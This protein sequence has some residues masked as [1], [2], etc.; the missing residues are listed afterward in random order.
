MLRKTAISLVVLTCV[1]SAGAQQRVT[2]DQCVS[3]LREIA[4]STYTV[5]SDKALDTLFVDTFCEVVKDK[6]QSTQKT[7]GG[8][9]YDSLNIK[10]TND[11]S[12]L[13][14]YE[15][16]YCRTTVDKLKFKSAYKFYAS[17]VN[18]KAGEDF[19]KCM[20]L[21]A[22][23]E[24]G[25]GF[26]LTATKRNACSTELA[27]SYVRPGEVGP[28]TAKVKNVVEVGA[29][30]DIRSKV[31]TASPQPTMCRRTSWGDASVS[32]GTDQNY[33]STEFEPV[34]PP[35]APVPP[36]IPQ[37]DKMTKAFVIEGRFGDGKNVQA[38]PG[39]DGRVTSGILA[40]GKDAEDI[41]VTY[42]CVSTDNLCGFSFAN[43]VSGA[44]HPVQYGAKWSNLG[45]GNVKWTRLWKGDASTK[46]VETY[47]ATWTVPHVRT[48]EENA[49]QA[50]YEAAVADHAAL[51]A[52]GPCPSPAAAKPTKPK[53][54]SSARAAKT[55][56]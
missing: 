46:I 33:R 47:T 8:L 26:V 24:G 5:D 1:A 51:L 48:A 20:K 44:P 38:Q 9:L 18:P 54:A 49:K 36:N 37:R 2:G 6:R 23:S 29:K 22:E 10:L 17:V 50:A 31:L 35:P 16:T 41:N 21:V 4:K 27:M 15:R 28:L 45:D 55:S 11:Q 56:S 40:L 25:R 34:T 13:S 42:D 52:N 12:Q 30:C 19:N 32:I 43:D 53:A 14:D 39:T 7:D 3:A